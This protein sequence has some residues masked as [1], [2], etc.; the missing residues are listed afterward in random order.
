MASGI[1]ERAKLVREMITLVPTMDTRVIEA[2][3]SAAAAHN[4]CIG[5]VES[6]AAHFNILP[7]LCD[8]QPHEYLK[9]IQILRF[10]CHPDKHEQSIVGGQNATRMFKIIDRCFQQHRKTWVERVTQYV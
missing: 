2:L 3:E 10:V 1:G 6:V 9:W 8:I 7:R 4:A 5:L